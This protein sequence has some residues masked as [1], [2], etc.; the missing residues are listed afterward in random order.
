MREKPPAACKR[1]LSP[2]VGE[3]Q[4]HTQTQLSSAGLGP[5]PLKGGG[6]GT[7]GDGERETG[8]SP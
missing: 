6:Q 8:L 7:V 1:V 5:S 2:L 4:K 3:T